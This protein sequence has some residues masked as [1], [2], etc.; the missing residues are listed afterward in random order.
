MFIHV[1]KKPT[2][3]LA[4]MSEMTLSD[5]PNSDIKVIVFV[6]QKK[7]CDAVAKI[8][9]T[10]NYSPTVLHGGKSQDE[11]EKSLNGFRNG[12]FDVLVATDVA[13]RGLDIPDVTHI[14]NYDIPN[15]IENYCHRIG[16]TGR[17]GKE[18]IAISFVTENDTDVMYD[19]KQYL[20]STD[21]EIPRE[22]ANHP[23]AKAAVGTR[24][25]RG[26]LLVAS[27]KD[28]KIFTN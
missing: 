12:D 19:L 1:S 11:R 3:L 2:K 22:L 16:R 25:D 7:H 10:G 28:T 9:R 15:K 23:A 13:G 21:A 5:R 18:G 24:D 4:V 8:L 20:K 14:V 27:K 17:A 26:K 6:N